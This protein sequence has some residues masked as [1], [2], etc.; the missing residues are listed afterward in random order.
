MLKV[1][2]IRVDN[3]P[4]INLDLNWKCKLIY[5]CIN[6]ISPNTKQINSR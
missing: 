1:D 6:G 2:Q 3:N 4:P 5:S